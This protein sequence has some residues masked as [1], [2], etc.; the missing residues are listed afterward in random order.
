MNKTIA[1]IATGLILVSSLMFGFLHESDGP[2]VNDGQSV[3]TVSNS[4]E[5]VVQKKET[6]KNNIKKT[7][8]EEK[9][10]ED[11]AT[12]EK[13]SDSV[14]EA[15]LSVEKTTT[16]NKLI[17]EKTSENVKRE[18]VM[19]VSI[20]NEATVNDTDVE[21]ENNPNPITYTICV[22]SGQEEEILY[23]TSENE[24][25]EEDIRE[26][27]NLSSE[28]HFMN[29]EISSLDTIFVDKGKILGYSYEEI[30]EVPNIMVYLMFSDGAIEVINGNEI[31][32]VS[33]E[34]VVYQ[35]PFIAY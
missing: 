2:N 24:L 27:L 19:P 33:L 29:S 3:P 22:K 5:Q 17:D 26:Q 20:G 30:D 4:N 12:E 7:H 23:L 28:Y 21:I 9:S 8:S 18:E 14:E 6:K 11:V 35:Y 16:E 25:S 10:V 32:T 1:M 15:H 31:T 34:D 13:N